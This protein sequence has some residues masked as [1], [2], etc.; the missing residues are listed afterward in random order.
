M[1]KYQQQ[2]YSLKR[3]I[4]V[5]VLFKKELTSK[6]QSKAHLTSVW[7]FLASTFHIRKQK[8]TMMMA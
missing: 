4:P 6:M 3:E 2:N 1:R 5:P 7:P 8:T